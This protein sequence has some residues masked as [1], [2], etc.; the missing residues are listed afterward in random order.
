ME[1]AIAALRRLPYRD[2]LRTNHWH[3]VRALA[4]ERA[5]DRCAL[6]PATRRLQV[7]HRSYARKGFEQPEDLIVLCERCHDRHHRTVIE[8][9]A[10]LESAESAPGPLIS[11]TDIRWFTAPIE[12]QLVATQ[13]GALNATDAHQVGAVT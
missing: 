3:R 4:L 12:Q 11:A 2:Y 1:L 13:E 10:N 8:R 6:C 5:R 9:D 7:H